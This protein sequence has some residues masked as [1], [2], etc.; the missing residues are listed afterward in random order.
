MPIH[1][2]NQRLLE[3]ERSKDIREII[4]SALE[5]H[6]GQ[7]RLVLRA[8]MDLGVTG[9]TLYNWCHALAITISDYRWADARVRVLAEAQALTKWMAYLPTLLSWDRRTVLPSMATTSPGSNSATDR[10][11]SMKHS[12][13]RS[14]SKRENTSPKVSWEGI[15]LGRPRKER[16]HSSL[17]LPNI[18]TWTQES[19]PQ[20]TAQM[21]MVM[22]SSN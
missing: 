13:K 1:T 14:G 16:N 4:T 10:L 12:W 21:A 19:A 15:P 8:S 7:P 22:M 3:A 2:L 5:A 17:L 18:S 11:Q 20:M 6:R 9:T